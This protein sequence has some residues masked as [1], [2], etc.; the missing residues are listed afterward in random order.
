M[1][2]LTNSKIV[3][4]RYPA[5]DQQA[6]YLASRDQS[7]SITYSLDIRNL[8]SASDTLVSCSIRNIG[9]ASSDNCLVIGPASAA[10]TV[11]SFTLSQGSNSTTYFLEFTFRMKSGDVLV[12]HVNAPIMQV[13]LLS[14]TPQ[15]ALGPQG[16]RS[17]LLRYLAQTS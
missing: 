6:I 14:E 15:L 10:G 9:D 17:E 3:I 13:G 4:A 1:S 2:N 11:V 7:S 16:E 5:L 8:I 12:F